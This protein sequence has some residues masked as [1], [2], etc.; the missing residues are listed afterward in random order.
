MEFPKTY[1]PTHAPITGP[2]FSV[3]FRLFAT[4]L[5]FSLLLWSFRLLYEVDSSELDKNV[6]SWGVAGLAL[7]ISTWWI[8]ISSR[9]T[10]SKIDITQT[11][12]WTKSAPLNAIG[13]A[14]FMR[15]KGWEWLIAP[16]LYVRTG[17]GP[18]KTFYAATP[19]LWAEFEAL[20][21]HH[22]MAMPS[23]E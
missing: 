1:T 10:L 13:Y 15:I 6:I 4:F 14:K 9:I 18:F 23:Q 7:L 2:A 19:E 3:T 12:F 17:P 22:R 8:L 11:W 16:R 5:V 20:S 21:T